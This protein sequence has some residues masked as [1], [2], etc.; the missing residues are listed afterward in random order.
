[1]R[2]IVLSVSVLLAMTGAGAADPIADFF[3]YEPPQ[4]PVGG[5]CAAIA[6]EVGQDRPGTEIR[7]Q[8]L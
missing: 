3:N 1:M 7:R 6:S 4:P 2:S 5:D 8:A